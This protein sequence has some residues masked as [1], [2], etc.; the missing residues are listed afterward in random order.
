VRLKDRVAI[1]TGAMSGIGEASARLFAKEGARVTVTGRDES[2]GRTVV[3]AI[4]GSGGSA[5]FVQADVRLVDD[6]RRVV[7][8]S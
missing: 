1:V 8:E 2:R 6:C 4:A 3:A 5:I 7:A